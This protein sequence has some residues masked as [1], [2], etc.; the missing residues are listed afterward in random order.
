MTSTDFEKP[1]D[2]EAASNDEAPQTPAPEQAPE[3]APE[4]PAE[5]EMSM[6]DVDMAGGF[7]PLAKGD[8]VT[9]VERWRGP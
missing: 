8:I 9:G 4:E 7:K 6:A 2:Q 3:Q 5:P 1:E